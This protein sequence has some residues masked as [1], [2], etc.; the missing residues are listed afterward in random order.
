SFSFEPQAL[1]LIAQAASGSMRDALSLTDQAISYSAGQLSVQALQEMLGTLDQNHLVT[2]LRALAAGDARA[3]LAVAD[4]LTLRGLSCQAALADLA[5]L[6]SRIAIAQRLGAAQPDDPM[7]GDIDAL[8][9]ILQPDEVQLFYSVAVNSRHELSL[10]PDEY[11]G[12]VMT[13]LRMLALLP[14]DRIVPPAPATPPPHRPD[15]A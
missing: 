14:A 10:A 13:C 5:V 12:F 6:L 15:P 7:A 9:R 4:D 3:M 11:A 8:A 2:L 1:R